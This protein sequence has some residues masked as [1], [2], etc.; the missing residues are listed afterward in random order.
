M[1]ISKS[2]KLLL[3]EDDIYE[4]LNRAKILGDSGYTVVHTNNGEAA[5]QHVQS[6]PSIDLIL[7]DIDLGN[8]I[9]GIETAEKILKIKNLPVVFITPDPDRSTIDRFK[10]ITR[11]GFVVKNSGAF[12][13]NSSIEM[14]FELFEAHKAIELKN[15]IADENEKT[16]AKIFHTNSVLMSVSTVE[17]GI[18]LEV[19]ETFLKTLGY[20]REEI[21][22]KK[23]TDLN[24]WADPKDRASA[25]VILKRDGYLRHFETKVRTKNGEIHYGLFSVDFIEMRGERCMLSAMTDI[26]ES[27][28]TQEAVKQ[29]EENFKKIFHQAIV[30][31]ANVSVNG[32]FLELNSRFCEITGYT[33]DELLK[34]NYADITHPDDLKID[35][36]YVAKVFNDEID[37]FT[38][39]KRY[40]HKDGHAV[41]VT[42]YSNVLRDEKR[43]VKSAIAVI[44]DITSKK[45]IEENLIYAMHTL[46]DI[47]NSI[48]SGLFIYQFKNPDRLYLI[49]A[50]AEAEKMTGLRAEDWIGKE[51]NE[52]WPAA[53][54]AGITAKY[55]DVIHS[56][57]NIELEDELYEDER[58][59]GAFRIRAFNIPGCKLGIAFENITKIKIA[60]DALRES[61]SHYHLLADHMSDAVWLMDMN[62]NTTYCSPSVIKL[63]GYTAEEIMQLPINQN[64]TEDSFN[65]A[66]KHFG[67]EM[68]KVNS[69]PEYSFVIPMELEYIKKDG[70]TFLGDSTF[71]LI[72]GKNG[73]PESIL[74]EARDITERKNA[75]NKINKL[76]KEKELLLKEVHHR[77]KNNMH[78]IAS[79]LY[80]QADSLNDASA[81]TALTDAYNRVQ[82]MMLI[83]EKLYKSSDFREISAQI[84]LSE[85]IDGITSTINTSAN[86][87]IKKS[88][89]ACPVNTALLF[90]V[91][92][93]INELMTNSFKY[94]FPENRKGTITV[95][96][97]KNGSI[98]KINFSDDGVGIPGPVINLE[99]K[100][101]GI[102][103]VKILTEQLDG[104]LKVRSN[105]GAEFSITFPL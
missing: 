77:I 58:V 95:S 65:M 105:N 64:I 93:I 22:G 48:P 37:S 62:L 20:N 26:T 16:F 39:D 23:S 50:N 104:E 2:K 35:E 45:Q 88:I 4:A 6:D 28:L 13:L 36:H 53:A 102:N 10:E 76:L 41:W 59:A 34:M 91:G 38:I 57:N 14:A 55:L 74:G 5:V 7:V 80:L 12:I 27:K 32:D 82:S 84:Y 21:I 30:G 100:G 11:Y 89:E 99:S 61:E 97:V 92:I 87:E 29:S 19:N 49:K 8:G 90:P 54:E 63:R 60:E 43:N 1:N 25:I 94:A 52:I 73:Q 103:L 17:D 42:L 24:L 31:I 96:L 75:E 69:D 71:T 18:Y 47:I 68:P 79:L 81:V 98:I 67:I 72:R 44:D 101:F 70:T 33:M 78:T 15:R 86:I 9:S 40:I 66:M 83:Y 56:G 51:F 85:L 46:E 3:A